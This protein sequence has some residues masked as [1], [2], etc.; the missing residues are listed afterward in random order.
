[1][2]WVALNGAGLSADAGVPPKVLWR[3]RCRLPGRAVVLWRGGECVARFCSVGQ[4][5]GA[6]RRLV[7]AAAICALWARPAH[8][9]QMLGEMPWHSRA[10]G[11]SWDLA[12]WGYSLRQN[13][14]TSWYDPRFKV[15]MQRQNHVKTVHAHQVFDKMPRALRHFL[16]WPKSPDQCLFRCRR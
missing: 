9:H 10:L 4:D 15:T 16:E 8:A 2:A 3:L 5:R 11:W 13:H 6:T 7:C 12:G 1:M 14:W